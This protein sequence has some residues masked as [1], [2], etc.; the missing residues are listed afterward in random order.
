MRNLDSKINK[1]QSQGLIHSF[2][3]D[4]CIYI[5]SLSSLEGDVTAEEIKAA[6][7]KAYTQNET[8]MSKIILDGGNAYYQKMDATG[9][10]VFIEERG[11][12]ELMYESER[13]PFR[14]NEGELFRIYIIPNPS[15]KEH[16]IFMMA[17]HIAADG[18]SL[19]LLLED[20]LANLSGKEVEYR[21]LHTEGFRIIPKNVQPPRYIR[22]FAKP[23]NAMW[24]KNKKIFNWDDYYEIHRQ[25]WKSRKLEV[26]LETI[27]KEELALI[28]AECKE[29]GITVNS[30]IVTKIMKEHPEYKT[31]VFPISLRENSRAIANQAVVVKLSYEYDKKRSFQEN[32]QRLHKIIKLHMGDEN[33]KY[34]VSA[35]VRL[36]D[37]VLI[38][39]ALM[40]T[41]AGYKNKAAEIAAK[42]IGYYGNKKSDVAVTNLTNISIQSDYGRFRLK[43]TLGIA[44][45]MSA[46]KDIVCVSTFNGRMTIAYSN[47]REISYEE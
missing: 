29:L 19:F 26:E 43:S 6:V 34:M 36:L 15:K 18:K 46:L 45:R 35:V 17:H 21:T 25:F 1:S 5:S 2:L 7:E 9:C 31:L 11:W 32:A 23:L 16:T 30:Y 4:P 42:Q 39:A 8:T 27:E 28:K 22:S 38:D 47:M 44:A 33:K 37:P 40:Y 24:Q 12:R 41:Y 13:D 14:I 10:T 3:F 20:I